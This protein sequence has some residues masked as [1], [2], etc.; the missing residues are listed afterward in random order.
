[1]PIISLRFSFRQRFSV[2]A[3]AAFAWC[4]DYSPGDVAYFPG[5]VRRQVNRIA[6]DA[7]VMTDTSVRKGKTLEISRLVRIDPEI[8]TWTSTHLNGP[9]QHSQYWYHIIPDSAETSHLD[10][11]GLRLERVPRALS[12]A[13][14]RVRTETHRRADLT[15]WRTLLAPALE[16]DLRELSSAPR[17]SGPKNR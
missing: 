3:R 14:I 11:E 13:E 9:Y 7:I 12:A 16:E 10:F 6:E 5:T 8:M 15:E 2:P 1:M 4:T 17:K